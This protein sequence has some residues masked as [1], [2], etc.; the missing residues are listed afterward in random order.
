MGLIY[1]FVKCSA[2]TI[3]SRRRIVYTRARTHAPTGA[4]MACNIWSRLIAAQPCLK[5]ETLPFLPATQHQLKAHWLECTC[6]TTAVE[7]QASCLLRPSVLLCECDIGASRIERRGEKANNVCD[8]RDRMECFSRPMQG[9][10]KMSHDRRDDVAELKW[11]A[12]RYW[13]ASVVPLNWH[14]EQCTF[15]R[16]LTVGVC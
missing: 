10:I 3:G 2:W 12:R 5:R 1:Q 15:T 4:W 6:Q 14:F 16:L 11:T 13:C 8:L 7:P 9:L